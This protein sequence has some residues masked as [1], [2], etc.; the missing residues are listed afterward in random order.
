MRDSQSLQVGVEDA[1]HRQL[2][3]IVEA[4]LRAQ[5]QNPAQQRRSVLPSLPLRIAGSPDE[6]IGPFL[7][8][9]MLSTPYAVDTDSETTPTKARRASGS[10]GQPVHIHVVYHRPQ[11]RVR[12]V[13]PM[14]YG[15]S[16]LSNRPEGSLKRRAKS[17][18]STPTAQ[19]GMP[20]C[21]CE[22]PARLNS[23]SPPISFSHHRRHVVLWPTLLSPI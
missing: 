12:S 20:L 5:N 13:S 16:R 9:L 4:L 1:V 15:R 11:R 10:Q 19:P 2:A 18:S 23:V 17:G 3:E 22:S 7:P 21:A 8:L 14:K 6:D